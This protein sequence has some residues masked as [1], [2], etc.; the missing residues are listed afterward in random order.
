MHSISVI[1]FEGN[2]GLGIFEFG[3]VTLLDFEI[4]S[5]RTEFC[6]GT[7]HEHLEYFL[8][9]RR[10]GL[11]G[12]HSAQTEDGLLR[13]YWASPGLVPTFAGGQMVPS[14]GPWADTKLIHR[15]LFPQLQSYELEDLVASFALFPE[16]EKLAKKY[17]CPG[18]TKFHSALFDALAT[19]LLLQNL[20][21]NF[22]N[23]SLETLL[24]ICEK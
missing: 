16:L 3:V 7:F 10:T 15:K 22:A 11:L 8:S 21:K 17:C 20:Q 4:I 14:W 5:T 2:K 19:S 18:G 23:V 24:A 6:Q 1:D 13:H 12:A 9:L